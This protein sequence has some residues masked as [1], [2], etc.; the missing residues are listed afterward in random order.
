MWL[1][2]EVGVHRHRK[3]YALARALGISRA[4]VV[5]ILSGLWSYASE[6]HADGEISALDWE[7]F[8]EQIGFA[9]R[10]SDGERWVD[11]LNEELRDYLVAAGFVDKAR[12]RYFL[13]DWEDFQGKLVERRATERER[14]ARRR[15]KARGD[16]ELPE[17]P[18]SDQG[19]TGGRPRDDTR[20]ASGT[21]RYDTVRNEKGE[22]NVSPGRSL[23]RRD[24]SLGAIVSRSVE[25]FDILQRESLKVGA[26]RRGFA[27]LVFAYWA[28][29][30]G[31]R[32]NTRLD[33]KRENRIV[34][35]LRE[36]G[37]NLIELLFAVDGMLRDDRLMGRADDSSRKYDGIENV[38]RDRAQVERLSEDGGY[39]ADTQSHPFLDQLTQGGPE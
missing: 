5:G 2:V 17:E 25:V 28:A 12:D 27:E 38:F 13:H 32:S 16:E 33:K 19:S 31:R 35:S 24:K 26:K 30:T 37:D 8:A 29:R 34:G 7:A 18:D 11:L 3:T 14:S 15:R 36:N 20:S 1:R 9:M 6:Q 21:V 4:E 10:Q 23:V 22:T 39:T